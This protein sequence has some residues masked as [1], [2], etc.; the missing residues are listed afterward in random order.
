MR[1]SLSLEIPKEFE[2]H[3]NEDRFADSLG[4]L[5]YDSEHS[6]DDTKLAGN[7][8]IEVIDMLAKALKNAVIES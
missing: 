4:R 1:V 3:F 2:Q 5:K 8:E 7:Y 6:K